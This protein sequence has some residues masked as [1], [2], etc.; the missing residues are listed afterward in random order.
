LSN[1]CAREGFFDFGA[2]GTGVNTEIVFEGIFVPEGSIRL[3]K[4]DN[5]V[6]ED[7]N[8]TSIPAGWNASTWK[9]GGTPSY[10]GGIAKLNGTRIY[11]SEKYLPGTA[12]TFSAKF[13]LGNYENIGFAQNGNFVLTDCYWKG[14]IGSCPNLYVRTVRGKTFLWK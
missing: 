13:S 4:T 8:S 9:P 1:V 14:T 6:T 10:S 3:K 2:G 7:F 12:I 5:L 11:S